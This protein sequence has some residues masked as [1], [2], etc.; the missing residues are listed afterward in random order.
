LT[1][2][3]CPDDTSR[4]LKAQLGEWSSNLVRESRETASTIAAHFGL[5]AIAVVVP[6]PKIGAVGGIFQQEHPIATDTTMAIAQKSNF[7]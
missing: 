3:R 5:T 1:I 2:E 7:V 6:H 4:C